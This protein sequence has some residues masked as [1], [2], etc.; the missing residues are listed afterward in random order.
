VA[1]IPGRL[2]CN[3]Y[4]LPILAVTNTSPLLPLPATFCRLPCNPKG[5]LEVGVAFPIVALIVAITL[6]QQLRQRK[7][8]L[9]V[10]RI[11]NWLQTSRLGKHFHF[12]KGWA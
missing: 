1:A 7:L 3:S 10:A 11:V 9:N 8:R 2:I 5:N 12:F 4:K 6:I